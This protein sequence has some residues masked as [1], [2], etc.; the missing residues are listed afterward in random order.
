M[1]TSHNH[2]STSTTKSRLKGARDRFSLFSDK[3]EDAEIQRRIRDGVNLTGATPWILIFAIFIASV[4]LNVNSTAV[5]IG[6]MLISPLMGPIMGA[7]LGV[8]VYDFDLVKRALFNLGMATLISL[9]VST[10]YFSVSPL[11]NAQSELLSRVSPTIWD[12]L[13]AFFGGWAGLIGITRTEKSNVIPGVAI[14]TAL[15]PPVCTAGFGI[16]TGKWS[17]VGGALY[18][19]TINCV[20]IGLATVMGS[21][22]LRLKR[23][24]FTDPRVERRV[25]MSLLVIALGTAIPSAYLAVELVN[26][27]VYKSNANNFITQEFT[28]KDTQVANSKI[29]PKTRTIELALIGLPLS[30]STLKNIE[31]RLAVAQLAGT[32][33]I[34]HQTGSNKVDVTALKAGLLSDLYLNGEEALR[35]KNEQV[36]QL[37]Q[38]ISTKNALFAKADD[39]FAELRA[40]YPIVTSIFVGQGVDLASGNNKRTLIQLSVRSSQPI[41]IEN[42]TRI[43]NWFKVRAK[44][45]AVIFSFVQEPTPTD[46][47]EHTGVVQKNP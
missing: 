35:K 25:K 23:H 12:V 27:E 13:I 45:D 37:Q 22:I 6:A 3:A 4:G 1:V 44:T 19:Y 5:I 8:A 41:S 28:L 20:F 2:N 34:V 10:L 32:K 14:A 42:Q 26:D 18:L 29:D 30:Q 15:M 47:H 16:A 7:G 38:E 46:Q 21:R 31:G 36:K 11:Q 39:I 24:G 33:I 17:F 43:E 9:I 40:Q